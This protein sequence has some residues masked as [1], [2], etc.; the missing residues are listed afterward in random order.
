MLLVC[1]S[2]ESVGEVLSRWHPEFDP[3]RSARI[4]RL[5]PSKPAIDAVELQ[6]DRRYLA[7]IKAAEKLAV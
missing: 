2:T 7:G 3:L 1:N 5:V 4:G 6:R